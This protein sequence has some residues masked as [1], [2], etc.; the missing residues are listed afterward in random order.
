MLHPAH[1]GALVFWDE[2]FLHNL[3]VGAF[4][5]YAI[6]LNATWLVNSAA[7]FYGY[8]LYDKNIDP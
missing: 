2:T 1:I 3:Y 5:R 4:L 8:C 7:Y 6:V